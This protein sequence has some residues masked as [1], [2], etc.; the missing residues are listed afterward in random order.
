MSR[1]LGEGLG[2]DKGGVI[3]IG[4]PRK[5]QLDKMETGGHEEKRGVK[6]ET[7]RARDAIQSRV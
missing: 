4:M 3:K 2:A 1:F 7:R 5:S 6:N